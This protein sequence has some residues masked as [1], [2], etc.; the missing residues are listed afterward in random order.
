[1]FVNYNGKVALEI[2]FQISKSFETEKPVK[3]N[4]F[5]HFSNIAVF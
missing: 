3:I 2:V 1:M 5:C 4:V